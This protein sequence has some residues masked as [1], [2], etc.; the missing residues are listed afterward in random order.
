MLCVKTGVPAFKPAFQV[1]VNVI[2]LYRFVFDAEIVKQ[3]LS[4]EQ[5]FIVAG[6]ARFAGILID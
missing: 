5:A 4:P 6:P 1:D 3:T 2:A